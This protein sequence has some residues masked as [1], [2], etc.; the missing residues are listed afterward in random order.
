METPDESAIV[1]G[2]EQITY[3]QLDQATD[4]L[5][6]YFRYCGVST[7]DPVGIFMETCPEY[8][9][10]SIGTLKAGA[11]F[12]PMGLD[13]PEPLLRAIVAEIAAQG[14]GHQIS[15]LV[16]TR[17]IHGDADIAY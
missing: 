17:R 14:G 5:G 15:V 9:V 13:S 11:A 16:Q 2:H 12:M 4:A 8:I 6:A 1:F 7:D 10:A 3:S